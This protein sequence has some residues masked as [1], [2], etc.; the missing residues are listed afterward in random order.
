MGTTDEAGHVVLSLLPYD[1]N[2]FKSM[3]QDF[4]WLEKMKFDDNNHPFYSG[5]GPE[6]RAG[7]YAGVESLKLARRGGYGFDPLYDLIIK[8]VLIGTCCLIS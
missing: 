2:Y 8:L 7:V 5:K 1:L 6:E 4:E 3:E